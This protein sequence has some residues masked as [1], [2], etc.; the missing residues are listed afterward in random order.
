M[1]A[2]IPR[3]E[4]LVREWQMVCPRRTQRG[5]SFTGEHETGWDRSAATWR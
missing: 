5:A 2:R 3:I 4:P 1:P